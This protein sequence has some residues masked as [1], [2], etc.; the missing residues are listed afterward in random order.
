[1][2]DWDVGAFDN[3]TAK[4][5]LIELMAGESTSAILRAIVNVAKLPPTDYLQA[6]ECEVAVAAAELVVAARGKPSS[7]LPAD[8]ANWISKRKFVAGKEVVAMALKV[9]RRIEEN[10][11]LKEVWADTDSAGDWR[12][13]ISDLKHRLEDSE[14]D[15]SATVIVNRAANPDDLFIKA[16]EMAAQGNHK[17]AIPI[18]EQVL[19]LKPDSALAY[20]GRGTA[21]LELG[22]NKKAATDIGESIMLDG[23][24][25]EAYYLRAEAYFRLADYERAMEDLDL[26]VKSEPDRPEAY[27]KRGLC[28]QKMRHFVDA[29]QD[30][31]KVIDLGFNLK[32]AYINRADC[33]ESLTKDKEALEDRQAALA[34]SQKIAAAMMNSES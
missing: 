8:A 24:V 32:D 23:E 4:E 11:E 14:N 30:F 29:V 7:H 17:D 6:P 9:L 22:E 3:D 2:G 12:R 13:S 25:P 15:S 19:E 20:L 18:Y 34:I 27:W 21:Y 28:L 5:W 31:T 1:M 26:L 10:S 33:Y 16:L